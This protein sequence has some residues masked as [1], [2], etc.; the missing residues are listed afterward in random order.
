MSFGF[1]EEL[2]GGFQ[3]ADLEIAALTAT[4]NREARLQARGI[5]AHGAYMA[6]GDG[7]TVCRECGAVFATT[8][9]LMA[10]RR[11]VLA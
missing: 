5:C 11:E 6:T 2:P 3:D 10:A 1:D 7:Q 4:A 8:E 9:S